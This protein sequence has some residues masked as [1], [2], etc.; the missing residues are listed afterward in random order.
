M[1]TVGMVA[2]L[3]RYPVK[4]MLG[5]RLDRFELDERG[6]VGDRLYAVRDAEGRLGSGKSTRRFRRM[7]ALRH[8]RAR[9]VAG[10]PPLLVLADGRELSCTDPAATGLLSAELGFPVSVDREGAVPH[11]DA[12]PVHLL[13][14]AALGWL[15][16]ELPGGMVDERRFRPNLVVDTADSAARAD[17]VEDDWIERT[18]RIGD[19][20]RLRVVKRTARCAM[21][22][23]A[24]DGL[25]DDPRVLRTL[26]ERNELNFGVY[27][28]PV[29]GG[30]VRVGDPVA[31]E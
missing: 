4:S 17:L 23:Q 11:M 3:W 21:V 16:G 20:V 15:R 5:E 13:T 10:G 27:A 1:V 7:D 22:N 19:T 25:P 8:I 9:S 24:R 30:T 28:R 2:A 29:R 18:V 12:E 14:T 26:A 31:V 6:V